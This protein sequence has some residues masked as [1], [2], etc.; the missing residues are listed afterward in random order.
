M[1]ENRLRARN[2]FV[3]GRNTGDKEKILQA[4]RK[5]KSSPV[6]RNRMF[7]D[8]STATLDARRPQHSV[9]KTLKI[10]NQQFYTQP[11]FQANKC[12]GRAVT[13]LDMPNI[14]GLNKNFYFLCTLSQE[15]VF[16]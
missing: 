11:N 6:H 10:S 2:T 7:L 5:H 14:L 13:F 4:S 16:H 3:K 8:S 12:E 1:G 15:A 9:F